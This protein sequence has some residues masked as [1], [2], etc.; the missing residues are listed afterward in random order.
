MFAGKAQAPRC[1]CGYRLKARAEEEQVAEIR[2]HALEAHG[3]AFSNEEALVVLLRS[4][5]ESSEESQLHAGRE[6]DE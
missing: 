2:R 4:E 5:L 6:T 3:L 1:D